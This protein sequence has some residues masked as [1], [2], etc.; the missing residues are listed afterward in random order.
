MIFFFVG[1][2]AS[3]AGIKGGDHILEINGLNVRCSKSFIC[4]LSHTV[5]ACTYHIL[6]HRYHIQT[7]HI[8]TVHIQ[9]VI[10]TLLNL[11]RR[12]MLLFLL[13]NLVKNIDGQSKFRFFL[14]K[15]LP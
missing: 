12:I 8:Q 3:Q 13:I 1:G 10:I 15:L 7:V 5:L 4:E 6:N 2:A 14:L 9:T 11:H